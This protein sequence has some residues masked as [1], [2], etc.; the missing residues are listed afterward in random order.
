MCPISTRYLLY[1]Y[2]IYN[3]RYMYDIYKTYIIIYRVPNKSMVYDRYLTIRYVCVICMICV[4]YIPD[5]LHL[6]YTYRVSDMCVFVKYRTHFMH[7]SGTY[8]VPDRCPIASIST[9]VNKFT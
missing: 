7:I 6:Y 2:N 4:V 3:I 9:S 8:R 1:I 5:F